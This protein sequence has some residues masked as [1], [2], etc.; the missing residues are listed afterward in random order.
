MINLRK[1]KEPVHLVPNNWPLRFLGT[2]RPLR[3]GP[4]QP[5]SA[6]K[7]VGAQMFTKWGKE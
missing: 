5:H 4:C 1:W 2:L 7:M 6:W 3:M